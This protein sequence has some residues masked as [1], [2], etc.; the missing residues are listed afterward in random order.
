VS[1]ITSV[2]TALLNI[3][4][5]VALGWFWGYYGVVAGYALAIAFGSIVTQ[6]L[7]HRRLHLPLNATLQAL[8]WRAVLVDL[9]AMALAGVLIHYAGLHGI[10]LLLLV[11][12]ELATVCLA[13]MVVFGGLER[14]EIA[15]MKRLL[16]SF[17]R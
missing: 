14:D 8:P 16:L 9:F 3:G 7:F 11:V 1:A 2:V 10:V 15:T 12:G 17:A 6:A 13:G 4:L 5:S